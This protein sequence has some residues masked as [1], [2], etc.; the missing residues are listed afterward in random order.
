MILREGWQ[1][2]ITFIDYSAAFDTESQMFLDEALAEAGVSSKVRR[3]VQA[4]FEAA[5]GVVRLRHPDRTMTLSEPFDI[6]RGPPKPRRCSW[7]GREC[8]HHVEVRVRG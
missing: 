3:I 2:I 6:A 1:A 5:T 7:C 8:D 4:I